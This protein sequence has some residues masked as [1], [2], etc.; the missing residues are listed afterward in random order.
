[1]NV[2]CDQ[3]DSCTVIAVEG[4][5]AVPETDQFKEFMLERIDGGAREILL[6]LK[7]VTY[8]DSSGISVLLTLLQ[9]ARRRGGDIRLTGVNGRISELFKQV[10]LQHV[11]RR[12][13]SRDEAIASFASIETME[14]G[15]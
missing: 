14:Y 5:I 7:K 9:A 3:V 15:G 8:L 10:G 13:D 4:D 1:M 12:F 2:F 11:F 6:D